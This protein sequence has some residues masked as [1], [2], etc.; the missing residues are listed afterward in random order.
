MLAYRYLQT[1]LWAA[2]TVVAISS[3]PALLM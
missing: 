3:Q 1:E 2:V